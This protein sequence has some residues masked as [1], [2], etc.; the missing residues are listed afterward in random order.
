M[1][2]ASEG[3]FAFCLVEP[4]DFPERWKNNIRR[5]KIRANVLGHAGERMQRKFRNSR[6]HKGASL[7]LTDI[8]GKLG[9]SFFSGI[10]L[11]SRDSS[12]PLAFFPGLLI[13]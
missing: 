1:R 3:S 8:L 6:G 12:S 13:N 4:V 5:N 9:I 7:P 10:Q 11:D 2:R